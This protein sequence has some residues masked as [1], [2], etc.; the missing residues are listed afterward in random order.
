[1][2]AKE[3]DKHAH[4]EAVSGKCKK[5]DEHTNT[6]EDKIVIYFNILIKS[7]IIIIFFLE[8]L[9]RYLVRSSILFCV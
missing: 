8:K 4:G 9:N 3:I 5:I 2:E 6:I 1:M 7:A